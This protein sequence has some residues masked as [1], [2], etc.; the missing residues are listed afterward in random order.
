MAMSNEKSFKRWETTRY[1]NKWRWE[2]LRRDPE[3]RQDFKDVQKL[4]KKAKYPPGYTEK[5]GNIVYYPYPQTPEGE[6]ER[7]YTAKYFLGLCVSHLPD[8][9]QSFEELI[10]GEPI[11]D[12]E[13]GIFVNEGGQAF[14]R[15]L[16]AQAVNKEAVRCSAYGETKTNIRINIDL[17]QINSI[18][19]LKRYISEWLDYYVE[20]FLGR[21][22]GKENYDKDYENII[23]VGDFSRDNPN[24]TQESIASE[25]YPDWYK[26]KPLSAVNTVGVRLKK[27]KELIAGGWKK[28]T[29][30]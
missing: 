7:E 29:F 22:A 28:I 19:Q 6:K 12:A 8:P 24:H 16:F 10:H 26:K 14:R 23:K 13:R 25:L 5:K 30:P 2:F 18:A 1:W 27:Y 17:D 11:W 4:R 21:S 3:Y 9:N 20:N 15:R